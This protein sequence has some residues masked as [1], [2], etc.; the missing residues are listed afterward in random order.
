MRAGTIRKKPTVPGDPC[1]TCQK[2]SLKR[3]RKEVEKS[4]VGEKTGECGYF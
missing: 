4:E 2:M 1:T 3:G